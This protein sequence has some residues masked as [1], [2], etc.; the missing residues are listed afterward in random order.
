MTQISDQ[1]TLAYLGSSALSVIQDAYTGS[2]GNQHP[3]FLQICGTA[4]DVQD[5]YCLMSSYAVS[6]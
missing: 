2:D 5:M 4:A 3:K 6:L 1:V